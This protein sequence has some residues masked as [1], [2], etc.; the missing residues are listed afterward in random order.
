MVEMILYSRYD[1]Y[2]IKLDPTIGS[3]IN[4][5]RPCL[6]ISPNI[7]NK[8]LNVLLVAPFTRTKK[9]YPTRIQSNFNN[10]ISYIVLD[11]MR[12]IDKSR[13][14]KKLGTLDFKEQRIVKDKLLE[15]FS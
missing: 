2:L 3:E 8:N 4:K 11:Q 13:L 6:I 12:T 1:I 14:I 9:I 7:S 10:S 15:M 5:T